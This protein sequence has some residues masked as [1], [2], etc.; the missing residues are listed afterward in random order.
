VRSVLLT[1]LAAPALA[2]MLCGLP[3]AANAQVIILPG[4]DVTQDAGAG[5]SGASN[6]T[7]T[8]HNLGPWSRSVT[9]P[10]GSFG[11]GTASSSGSL[12]GLPSPLLSGN[13]FVSMNPATVPAGF[14]KDFENG[15]A[16]S[17]TLIYA[18][19]VLGPDATAPVQIKSL[20]QFTTGAATTTTRFDAF[21]N[22]G[23]E[24]QDDAGDNILRVLTDTSTLNTFGSIVNSSP[25][26]KGSLATGFTGGINENGIYTLLTNTRYLVGL[27]LAI[28][29]HINGFGGSD[30]FSASLDPTFAIA[31]GTANSG[32]YSFIFSDG[33]GN[34]A[35]GGGGVPEPSV[36]ALMLIGFGGL[37][38]ALRRRRALAVTA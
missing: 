11:A 21:L 26:V 3:P 8:T 7:V 12:V 6:G 18:F 2:G 20:G 35:P 13:L 15:A 1:T 16:Y 19:E 9:S 29:M 38:A 17:A 25:D 28:D 23:I 27:Q 10:A 14:E 37:G 4:I 22:M 24:Q 32:A 36:W 30:T 5:A 33:I 34:T 31:P